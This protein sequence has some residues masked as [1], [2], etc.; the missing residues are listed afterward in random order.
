VGV[1]AYVEEHDTPDTTKEATYADVG[2]LWS[3]S[4]F[5]DIEAGQLANVVREIREEL[6][7]R[8]DVQREERGIKARAA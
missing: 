7:H 8:L 5:V 1:E 3:L 4:D 2:V 6:L